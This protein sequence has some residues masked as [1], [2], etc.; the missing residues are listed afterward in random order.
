LRQAHFV[1]APSMKGGR[2]EPAHIERHTR[3]VHNSQQID[4]RVIG[5]VFTCVPLRNDCGPVF[6]VKILPVASFGCNFDSDSDFII[7]VGAEFEGTF[8]AL[9]ICILRGH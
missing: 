8:D 7:G 6:P 3:R 4:R 9:R 2:R 5:A 1:I